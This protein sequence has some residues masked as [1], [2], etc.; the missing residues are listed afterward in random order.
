MYRQRLSV[1]VADDKTGG[2]FLDTPRRRE[3]ARGHTHFDYVAH[4][5]FASSWQ[6]GVPDYK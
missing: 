4:P 2:L 3:A 1:V 6:G 5:S